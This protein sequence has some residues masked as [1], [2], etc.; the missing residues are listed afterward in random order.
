[1]RSGCAMRA[2][3]RGGEGSWKGTLGTPGLWT[4]PSR[5]NSLPKSRLPSPTESSEP[6]SRCRPLSYWQFNSRPASPGSSG[7]PG[8]AVL[9][10][11]DLRNGLLGMDVGV[12]RRSGLIGAQG[13]LGFRLAP[14][15]AGAPAYAS[16]PLH[17]AGYG[18]Q[19]GISERIKCD[20]RTTRGRTKGQPVR[21]A[22]PE[23]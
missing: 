23:L 4:S 3:R 10:S 9:Y 6:I 14:L 7:S 8:S 13:G 15:P 20:S 19:S 2:R 1:M 16:N 5:F 11:A 17:P 12:Q 21:S 18:C 22:H